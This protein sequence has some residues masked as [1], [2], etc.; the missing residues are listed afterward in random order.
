M[1]KAGCWK[2]TMTFHITEG[3]IRQIFLSTILADM[4]ANTRGAVRRGCACDER[5][6][7]LSESKGIRTGSFQ[8][9]LTDLKIAMYA[10]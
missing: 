2:E 8:K 7:G 9:T 4:E 6:L 3:A 1:A 10:R 5:V